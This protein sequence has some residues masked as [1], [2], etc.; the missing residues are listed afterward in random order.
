MPDINLKKPTSNALLGLATLIISLVVTLGVAEL[1]IRIT[2]TPPSTLTTQPTEQHP[3]YG[4]APRPGLVGRHATMEFDYI[5]HHTAQGLRGAELFSTARPD[6]VRHRVLFLGDSFTYGNG[7]PDDETFVARIDAELPDTQVINTG[8]NGYGQRQQLA[9]LD[10]L[11]AALSPDLVIVMFFWNDAEDNFAASAPDFAETKDGTVRRTDLEI[12]A[13]FDPLEYR[14]DHYRAD[15]DR[16]WLRR[17]YLYKLIKEGARGFRH[18]WFGSRERRIQ[19]LQQRAA[20]WAV[21]ADLLH[22]MDLRSREIG[23]KL[24]VVS[25]PDY[26]RVTTDGRLKGQRPINIDI[27]QELHGVCM[28]LDLSC[29]DL[30]PALETRQAAADAPFY[31]QTDRHFTPLGNAAVADIL[32]PVIKRWLDGLT[33]DSADADATSR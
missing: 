20:A 16:R 5:F 30:L 12:P 29:V 26:E 21:T 3:V 9:I 14:T 10:T 24:V 7:S 11:G 17:T 6:S 22:L 4:W 19:T 28:Q 18:R 23:A 32:T 33:P 15:E 27:E 8:A 1:V 13:T 2:W 31:Y 25:I